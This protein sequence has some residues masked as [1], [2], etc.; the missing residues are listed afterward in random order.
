MCIRD[1]IVAGV[2]FGFE[3]GPLFSVA[4][5]ALAGASILYQTQQIVRQYPA[6]AY[7]GAA[8]GLFSSVMLLFWYV[9]RLMMQLNRS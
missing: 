9:L 4:M 2:V 1:R 3:L 7:V 6:W 8:V 5:I